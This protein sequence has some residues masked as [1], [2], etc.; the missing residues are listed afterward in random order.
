VTVVALFLVG[1]ASAQSRAFRLIH[2]FNGLDGA[3]PRGT[4]AVARNGDEYGVATYGGEYSA[5]TVFKLAAPQTR[6][7]MWT[8]TVLYDF[9][10]NQQGGGYPDS[11]ILGTDGN[12]YGVNYSQTIFE[13]RRPKYHNGVWTYTILHTLN[14]NQGAAI[15]GNLVFDAEGNLYGAAG[16]GGDMSCGIQGCGTVFELKR[17][18]RKGGKW[19]LKVLYAFTGLVGG[20]EEPF[21]GVVFDKKGDLYGT[22]NYGGVFGYGT[23]Y[24]LGHPTRK[25]HPWTESVLYSFDRSS[26]IGS[27]AGSPVIFDPL[28]NLYGTTAFGGDLNC[29]GGYGCGVVYELSPPENKDSAWSY[30]TLYA[31]QGGSDGVQPAGYMVFDNKGRLY[32]TTQEGG[33]TSYAGIAYR[34]TPEKDGSWSEMVLHRFLAPVGTGDHAGLV[35]GRWGD[36]YGMTYAGGPICPSDFVYGCGTVFE[37]RP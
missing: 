15:T 14:P 32:G 36:F 18:S 24:R 22:T 27:S 34:L 1:A 26:N 29:E 11:L 5:G 31:F 17:P 10:G 8:P 33:G 2:S 25:G 21:A 13:L 16:G 19:H 20:G 28:G 7:A 23:V 9:P 3:E 6:D 35:P 37:L 4:P 12:L 30:A